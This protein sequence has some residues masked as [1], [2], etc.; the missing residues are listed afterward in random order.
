MPVAGRCGDHNDPWGSHARKTSPQ[1][2]QRLGNGSW[3]VSGQDATTDCL[4]YLSQRSCY[5]AAPPARGDN[6]RVL[7]DLKFRISRPVNIATTTQRRDNGS[8][9]A[10]SSQDAMNAKKIALR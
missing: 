4:F 6:K 1:P 5:A 9:V 2:L 8:Q 3:R 7:G 10:A